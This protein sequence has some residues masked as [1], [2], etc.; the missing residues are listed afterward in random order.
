MKDWLP[1]LLIGALIL[2]SFVLGGF[3]YHAFEGTRTITVKEHLDID[4]IKDVLLQGKVDSIQL[5]V[6]F[7][8]NERLRDEIFH[9]SVNAEHDTLT[10]R[11]T[12]QVLAFSA[13][14]TLYTKAIVTSEDGSEFTQSQVQVYER[15]QY[16]PAFNLFR[17]EDLQL[18]PIAMSIKTKKVTEP[19]IH[20]LFPSFSVDALISF[21]DAPGAG[22][23]AHVG[24][25]GLGV[26]IEIDRKPMWMLAHRF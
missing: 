19:T 13:D 20:S 10:L 1:V 12:M 14:T 3:A 7:K 24:S 11:D 4:S 15:L 18:S 16:I 8:E 26:D 22:I 23:L 2:V 25:W 6:L 17:I 21:R 5:S 9:A